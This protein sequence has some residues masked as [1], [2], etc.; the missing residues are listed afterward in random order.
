MNCYITYLYLYIEIKNRI[1]FAIEIIEV[2]NFFEKLPLSG[3]V[4]AELLGV[5]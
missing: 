5:L 3:Y 1:S 4:A 2:N